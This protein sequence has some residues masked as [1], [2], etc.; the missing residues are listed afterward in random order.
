MK[1]IRKK[2][3]KNWKSSKKVSKQRKYIHNAPLHIRNKFVSA[4]LSKEL[5]KKYGVRNLPVRKGD[6]VKIARG[7]FKGKVGKVIKVDLKKIRIFIEGIT[8]EKIAG[9]KA[10]YPI[11]PS[12]IIITE[13]NSEDKKRF[14]H[15]TTKEKG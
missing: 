2:F 7:Q 5:M 10:P 1:K 3:S 6:K 12:N 4:H 9:G 8:Q 15:I 13:L 11:H 14:K